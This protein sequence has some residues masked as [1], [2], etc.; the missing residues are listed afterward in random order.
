MKKLVLRKQTVRKL[1]AD[2]LVH[3][4]G[5]RNP[6]PLPYSGIKCA[7]TAPAKERLE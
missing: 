3:V 2:L 7:T 4:A 5:G 1:S 6:A